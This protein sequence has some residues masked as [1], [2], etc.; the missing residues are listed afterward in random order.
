MPTQTVSPPNLSDSVVP[1]EEE[2][3]IAGNEGTSGVLGEP[4]CQDQ[5]QEGSCA[6]P[7]GGNQLR[8]APRDR[9]PDHQ[10]AAADHKGN[11]GF[12]APFQPTD[13]ELPPGIEVRS[14]VPV[15]ASM[16]RLPM[17]ATDVRRREC[18]ELRT[19]SSCSG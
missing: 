9:E 17:T 13:N 6:E 19:S 15:A 1:G 3:A 2:N 11:D 16:P 7:V 4:E 5:R 10:P 12:N 8:A 18:S 14:R